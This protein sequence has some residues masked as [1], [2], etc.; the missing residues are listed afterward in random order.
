MK[1]IS[2][3]TITYNA[4]ATLE[5]TIQSIINQ[6]YPN[7]E[8]IIIDGLSTD[9]T[10]EIIAQYAPHIHYTISE[11]DNGLYDAMNKGLRAATGDFVWFMNAGDYIFAPDTT[12]KI[13]NLLTE[14]TDILYGEVMLV[15]PH[16]RKQLGTRSQ[17]TPHQLPNALN[18]NSMRYG[19]TV[20]HQAFL[21]RRTIAPFYIPDNLCA[22]IDWV[23][24]CLKASRE[25]IHS[26]L[27]LAAFETGGLSR[28]RHR[29]SLQ[30]RFTVLSA[31]YGFFPTLLAHIWIILRALYTRLS[32]STYLFL[33]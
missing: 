16:T 22:D 3:I 11:K 32:R 30:D 27:I 20:S 13:A 33:Q 12:E 17:L 4:Q 1:T 9:K 31:H 15:E 29:T 8:Y 28:Q 18:I 24:K 10:P 25:N 19:M 23:I 7:I 21:V 5:G 2:I 14:N 6:T 26:H